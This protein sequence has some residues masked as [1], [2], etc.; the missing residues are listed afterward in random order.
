MDY[1]EGE[2]LDDTINLNMRATVQEITR[3]AT[4]IAG[5]IANA[6]L[7][8]NEQP[9]QNSILERSFKNRLSFC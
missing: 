1:K 4:L 8:I 7:H 6:L 3:G 9:A 5:D 2:L